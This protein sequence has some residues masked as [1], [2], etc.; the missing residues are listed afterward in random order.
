MFLKQ[1]ALKLYRKNVDILIFPVIQ[2]NL[3]PPQTAASIDNFPPR[4]AKHFPH[5]GRRRFNDRAVAQPALAQLCGSGKT[6]DES[7]TSSG[8]SRRKGEQISRIIA[9]V[10]TPADRGHYPTEAL[11]FYRAQKIARI[12]ASM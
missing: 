6:W 7:A 5:G 8:R 10:V 12:L 3:P 4:A 11:L 9:N 1:R 2:V